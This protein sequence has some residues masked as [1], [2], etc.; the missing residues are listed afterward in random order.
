MGSR[1][2]E[3]MSIWIHDRTLKKMKLDMISSR[4][5]PFLGI[6][7]DEC[8]QK[9]TFL[10]NEMMDGHWPLPKLCRIKMQES[11]SPCSGGV[12]PSDSS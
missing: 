3:Q 6:S 9:I 5:H 8:R 4:H 1:M 7:V 2:L 12:W 11:D 10:A